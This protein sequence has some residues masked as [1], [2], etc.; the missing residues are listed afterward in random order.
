MKLSTKMAAA[1]AATVA[2]ACAPAA[3]QES[4]FVAEIKEWVIE[5]CMEVAA[6]L[7]VKSYGADQI[8][9]G[10]KREHIAEVMTASRDATT[11]EVASKMKAGASWEARRAA[12]PLMLQ[13]CLRQLPG[14]K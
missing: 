12:Y 11:R 14:M 8:A 1:M 10:I 9:T 13:L 7:D 3:A 2:L 5:P 6:A 4:A